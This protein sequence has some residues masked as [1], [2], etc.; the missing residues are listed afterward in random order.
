MSSR[1]PF[2]V[3]PYA[4]ETKQ[5][6]DLINDAYAV[7]TGNTGVAFKKTLRFDDVD[8]L[9]SLLRT[10]R[11]FAATDSVTG[12]LLGAIVWEMRNASA[13]FGPFSVA[14]SAQGRGVGRELLDAVE[15]AAAAEGALS[16]NMTVINWR[17]DIIP[18]YERWGF[19]ATGVKPYDDHWRI[20]RPCH[21]IAYSRA[22]SR[23]KQPLTPV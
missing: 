3:A 21:F 12:A 1:P 8:E 9:D 11:C 10:S 4:G 18:M 5:L 13:F 23:A 17:T 14:Q 7:E 22:I 6:L 16:L 2:V 19:V 20:T 15:D